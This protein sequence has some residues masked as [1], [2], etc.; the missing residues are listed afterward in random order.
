[1]RKL[2]IFLGR[3]AG[4]MSWPLVWIVIRRTTRTRIL[5]NSGDKILVTK[6]WLSTGKWSLPGGGMHRGEKPAE[7]VLRELREETNIELTETQLKYQGAKK[8]TNGLPFRYHLFS[9]S[10]SQ[11]LDFK[12]QRFEIVDVQ[13][14]DRRELLKKSVEQHVREAVQA[15]ES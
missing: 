12:K 15:M 10:A 14:L 8:Q 11:E 1:M 4:Y 9:A 13:W 6:G 2:W 7:A 3:I 5:L